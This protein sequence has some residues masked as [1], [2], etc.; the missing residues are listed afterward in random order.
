M[1][2][3][4]FLVRL[5]RAVQWPAVPANV[6]SLQECAYALINPIELNYL[7]NHITPDFVDD[8]TS[9][10]QIRFA[11][12]PIHFGFLQLP[13]SPFSF[14]VQISSYIGAF[15]FYLLFLTTYPVTQLLE[16]VFMTELGLS[17]QHFT[18]WPCFWS[19]EQDRTCREDP[20]EAS[21]CSCVD[22][23]GWWEHGTSRTGYS[24]RGRLGD[25]VQ[26]YCHRVGEHTPLKSQVLLLHHTQDVADLWR[27]WKLL[28]GSH[29]QPDACTGMT[30][31]R[32]HRYDLTKKI[33]W[34]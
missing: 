20:H 3:I 19:Y 26:R 9:Q 31:K 16:H 29:R 32:L 4:F 1:T 11:F 21:A 13:T 10:L 28:T 6:T 17:W 2:E 22:R 7:D 30:G 24:R 23:T 27:A 34:Q 5:V 18:Q 8:T 14:I 15:K 33:V 25:V 12:K